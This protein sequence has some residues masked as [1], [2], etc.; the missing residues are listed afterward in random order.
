V[1]LLVLVLA[2]EDAQPAWA[3]GHLFLEG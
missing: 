2:V 1:G 3:V